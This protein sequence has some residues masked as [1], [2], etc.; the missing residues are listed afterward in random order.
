[1]ITLLTGLPGNGKTLFA[2]W[3]I[4]AK[5]KKEN[6]EVYYH[7]I[8]DLALPWEKFEPE[9]WMDL[10]H[11]SIIVIDECQ[12]VFPK[13]PNGAQLPAHYDQL[14][15]HRHRGFDIFLI[16]QHPTLIDN[17]ARRLVGQHF[18][19]IRKFGLQRATVYE[20]SACQPSPE[21]VSS[22]KSAITLK[23]A[24][25]KEVFTWYKS[26]EVHTVKRAIPVKL[27]LACL[28]V[29]AVP[30]FGY[31]ALQTYQH[32]YDKPARGA[33]G[34][35]H[36][37]AL[38][39]AAPGVLAPTAPATAASSSASVDP[40]VDIKAYVWKETP[41]VV[42]LVQTAPKYDQLTTP[43]RVPIPAMCIQVG[44]L[45]V[46]KEVACKCYSQQ[47]TAMEDVPYNM[48]IQF[49]RNGFFQ[50]FDADRDKA[51]TARTDAGREALSSRPDSPV[52]AHEER[53]GGHVVAFADVPAKPVDQV[54]VSS[55][56]L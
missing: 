49:A 50:E 55:G 25:P 24:Y 43:Q 29:L 51:A 56:S 9:K 52:P 10:P 38:P 5:A 16:T 12:E 13:K 33:S 30:A 34:P 45:V 40:L 2:L 20:W 39:G 1:M 27:V 22:Q 47:A 35:G 4:Q 21:N 42:G 14:A 11:G 37:A 44:K 41:R 15:T 32:R 3:S 36:V 26:A 31:Y 6:R 28:F 53:A 8:K 46:G 48:C 17:F 23:W 7:N 18:H 54:R 19:S